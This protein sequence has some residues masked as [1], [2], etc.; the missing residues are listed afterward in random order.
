MGIDWKRKLSS[1]KFWSLLAALVIAIGVLFGMN[2]TTQENITALVGAFGAIAVYMLA[3]AHTD[4]S[5]AN[6][7]VTGG[8]D[9]DTKQ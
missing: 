9:D 2:A 1:R 3:E 6:K 5:H 8:T 7:D 4:A